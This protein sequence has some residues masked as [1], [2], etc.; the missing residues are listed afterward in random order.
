MSDAFR[1]YADDEIG[2][3]G[4]PHAWSRLPVDHPLLDEADM[5]L[6]GGIKDVVR[7]FADYRCVRCHH[8]YRGGGEWTRC[9]TRC[10]HGDEIR[11]RHGSESRWIETD[12]WPDVSRQFEYDFTHTT[13]D[14]ANPR[15]VLPPLEVEAHWRVLTVH[16]LNGVKADC[17]CSLSLCW[18][19][20]MATEQLF[21]TRLPHFCPGEHCQ[22]PCTAQTCTCRPC[23]PG[24]E[25]CK[26]RRTAGL[27]AVPMPEAANEFA[28]R[29]L[30]LINDFTSTNQRS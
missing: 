14:P 27:R 12:S 15:R 4:Y 5:V 23:G 22:V 7:A 26:Q 30:R 17:R 6:P 29:Q 19:R 28:H 10:T 18:R 11:Y 21:S 20:L 1:I 9:D 16:H 2:K 13:I 25:F 24:C 3:K 8:R